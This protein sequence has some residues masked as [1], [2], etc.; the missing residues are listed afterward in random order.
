[1]IDLVHSGPIANGPARGLRFM[2]FVRFI[3]F[4]H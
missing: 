2:H 3:Y 1:M 4:T